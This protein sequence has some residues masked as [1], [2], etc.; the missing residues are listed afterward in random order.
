ML[1]GEKL[2]PY[3]SRVEFQSLVSKEIKCTN[4][5]KVIITHDN[6]NNTYICKATKYILFILESSI[7]QLYTIVYNKSISYL[8][9]KCI[10]KG[11]KDKVLLVKYFIFTITSSFLQ[12]FPKLYNN[13]KSSHLK[14]IR[15]A[16]N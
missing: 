2:S 15:I 7:S 1:Y 5:K 10:K 6:K 11:N 8:L 14:I 16:F 9:S 12:H 3:T 4:Y 13:Y